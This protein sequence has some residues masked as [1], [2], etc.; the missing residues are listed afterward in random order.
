MLR[1]L[2]GSEMCIRDRRKLKLVDMFWYKFHLVLEFTLI[3]LFLLYVGNFY[4]TLKLWLKPPL[5]LRVEVTT[6]EPMPAA[7]ETILIQSLEG[8]ELLVFS[9]GIVA[10]V[11]LV[12]SERFLVRYPA[13]AVSEWRSVSE[14]FSIPLTRV[15]TPEN[16]SEYTIWLQ[17]YRKQSEAVAF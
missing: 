11:P 3:F 14:R 10:Y 15:V 12:S 13:G 16:E 17:T 6:T 7:L 2:V 9:D 1:S 8:Q 5:E 4:T